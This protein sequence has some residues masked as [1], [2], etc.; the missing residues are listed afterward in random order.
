MCEVDQ[1]G[2]GNVSNSLHNPVTV[3]VKS[4][5]GQYTHI[6]GFSAGVKTV[7]CAMA[8]VAG[9]LIANLV[10]VHRVAISADQVASDQRYMLSAIERVA[11]VT[12]LHVSAAST[13]WHGVVA[14]IT[15]RFVHAREDR[16][17]HIDHRL[18]E[19]ERKIDLLI[20]KVDNTNR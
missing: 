15:E 19:M 8:L 10:M 18:D 9:L 12:D 4:R 5:G 14:T 6:S 17:K 11:R 20:S 3:K 2:V 16:Q 13:N 1:E 7:L